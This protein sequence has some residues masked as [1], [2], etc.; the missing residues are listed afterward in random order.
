MINKEMLQ[1]SIDFW[2]PYSK[3]ELTEAK[4]MQDIT[5]EG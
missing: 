4:K 5:R 1:D 3:E 2:Q